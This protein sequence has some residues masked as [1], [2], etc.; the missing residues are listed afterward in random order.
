M[1]GRFRIRSA[2]IAALCLSALAC[3]DHRSAE[4]ETS[5]ARQTPIAPPVQIENA[6]VG[7]LRIGAPATDVHHPCRVVSDT[8][9]LGAEGMP[10]RRIVAIVPPDDT[11]SA[12][13]ADDSV[14]RIEVTSGTILTADSLGVG[15]PLRRLLAEP[16]A[17]ALEGEGR[18]FIT[19]PRHCGLSFQLAAVRPDSELARPIDVVVRHLP[20]TTP[21]SRVLVV[22]C[23]AS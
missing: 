1:C 15:T 10:E 2:F 22:G 9:K 3:G 17:R 21:V 12:T 20:P 19:V 14:W 8:T 13:I 23:P 6:G 11:L 5:A 18:I 4:R 7:C 16:G